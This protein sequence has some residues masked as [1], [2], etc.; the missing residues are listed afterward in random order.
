VECL[1][2]ARTVK[3]AEMAVAMEWLRKCHV[4]I[5]TILHATMEVPLAMVFSV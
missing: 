1:L 4:S 2:K 5:A 3:S